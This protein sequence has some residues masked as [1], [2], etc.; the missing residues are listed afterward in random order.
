[1]DRDRHFNT[2][3]LK[4]DL[5]GRAARGG[6]VTIFSQGLKF[7]LSMGAT[8]V[9]ARILTPQDYGLVAM[10]AVVVG[11]VSMFKDMGLSAATI[12]QDVITNEQ[13]STLFWINVLLSVAAMLVTLMLAPA[14]A[15]FFG[16]PR[17][18]WITIGFAA[19]FL[20][21][22]LSVQ[23]EALLKRQMR[24]T[25]L[26]VIEIGSLL[27][28]VVAAVLLAQR[29]A[30]YW[31]LV[32]NQAAQGVT[33]AAGVW[34][35][36]DWRPGRPVR[37]SG[38][39]QLLTFGANLTGF[40]I[41]NFAA[42]NVD[43][44]LI[45]KFWGGEQLGLYAKAYQLLILPIEQINGPIAA[46]AMPTL[47][48]LNDSPERYRQTYLRIL[49]KLA[50]ITM[51]GVAFMIVCADWMV[52][53][54]LGPQWSASGRIFALLSI[55]GLAQPIANTTGWLFMTQGRTKQMLRWGIIGSSLLVA[56]IVI[57]LP[58]GAVGVAASY[59]CI[60][61]LVVTPLL[62]WFVGRDG[63]VR[64]LDFYRAVAPGAVAAFSVLA[65]LLVLRKFAAF[66]SPLQG[67]V[68]S[69][70]LA[71]GVTLLSLVAW[72]RGRTAIKDFRKMF[73]LLTQQS[74]N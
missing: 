12:Q 65:S 32:A 13:V 37:A 34:L 53:I 27:C 66:H 62:F 42:R 4:R 63:P 7:L 47:S 33:Y 60:F 22:G 70:A 64:T 18:T 71:A 10:V 36:C 54:V 74:E 24:F 3:G 30:G 73:A 8:V 45:G 50:I 51:P 48:R 17:L 9:L 49:E 25:A 68:I 67:V 43:N 61:L 72:P 14:V 58:W 11:F 6:V 52:L 26:A 46:V 41:V 28:G 29:G 23:H 1:L 40:Q 59:S 5:A 16:E 31:A 19:G 57:G 44:M 35:L 38:V 55:S 39:R 56:S 20:A 21:G 69:F 2:A 15:W